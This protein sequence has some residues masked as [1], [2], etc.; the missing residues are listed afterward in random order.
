M[1]LLYDNGPTVG[2]I[3]NFSQS[4]FRATY[5]TGRLISIRI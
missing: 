3:I 1:S 2:A 5:E 4:I